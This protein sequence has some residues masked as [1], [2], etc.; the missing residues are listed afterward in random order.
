MTKTALISIS[1]MPAL[2]VGAVMA[3]CLGFAVFASAQNKSEKKKVEAKVE[4]FAEAA[5][6]ANIEAMDAILHSDFRVILNQFMGSP[7]VTIMTKDAYL[8]GMKA[9]KIGGTPHEM[10]VGKVKILGHT[11]IA[12]ATMTSEAM[13]MNIHFSFVQ[14]PDGDWKLIGDLPFVEMN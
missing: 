12:Q 8:A 10:K 6:A 13:T 9:G 14:N 5:S 3:L 11:A 7:D 2:K 4:A 1:L